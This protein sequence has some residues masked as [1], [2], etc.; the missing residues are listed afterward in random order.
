MA[1]MRYSWFHVLRLIKCLPLPL[2]LS[3]LFLFSS[4]FR[5]CVSVCVCS[6][7]LCVWICSVS[8]FLLQFCLIFS[9][10]LYLSVDELGLC[11]DCFCSF[12][13]SL[14]SLRI[15][16]GDLAVQTHNSDV[17]FL[18]PFNHE[19]IIVKYYGGAVNVVYSQTHSYL[20]TY[21]FEK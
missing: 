20:P 19:I 16:T 14:F 4:F 5:Y 21:D 3:P 15:C 2:W 11:Y 12:F 10:S 7:H 8:H 9:Y 13:F 17:F 1:N 6:F 18:E